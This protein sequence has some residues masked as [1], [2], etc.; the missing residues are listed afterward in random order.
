M[1]RKFLALFGFLL[2]LV[3]VLLTFPATLFNN[4][5]LSESELP[6]PEESE[7]TP[8]QTPTSEA[9]PSASTSAT[10]EKTPTP[11]AS[12]STSTPDTRV[13]TGLIYRADKY[14]DVQIQITLTDG[15]VTAVKV[16]KI[17]DADSRSLAISQMAVPTLTYQTIEAKNSSS[18]QGATGASYTSAAWIQSLQSALSQR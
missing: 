2:G 9:S 16:L 3:G 18:I 7:Q 5:L 17:P 1:R 4:P 10:V 8:T 13:I 6:V 14:G 15:S 12:T 11:T